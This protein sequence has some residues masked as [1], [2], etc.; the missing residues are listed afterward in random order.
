MAPQGFGG[1]GQRRNKS[2]HLMWLNTVFTLATCDLA[3][4]L[5]SG[6]THKKVR[7]LPPVALEPCLVELSEG[8]Q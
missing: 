3:F 8:I 5:I 4:E 2:D 1:T 6:R 7:Q